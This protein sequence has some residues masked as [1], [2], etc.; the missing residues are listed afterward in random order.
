M[1]LQ[2][3]VIENDDGGV[4]RR[5]QARGISNNNGGVSGGGVIDDA[6]EELETMTEAANI[7]GQRLRLRRCDDGPEES[8][9]TTEASAEEDEPK[10]LKTT[11]KASAEGAEEMTRQSESL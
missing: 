8:A 3:Q 7:W 9:L 2:D 11:R 10:Y 4:N 6:S 1:C 5:R